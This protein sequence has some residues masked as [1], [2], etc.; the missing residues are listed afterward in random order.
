MVV[1]DIIIRIMMAIFI[2]GFVGYEREMRNRPAGFVT[3]TLVC[4]GASFVAPSI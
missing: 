3:H 1:Q 4:V 2:G